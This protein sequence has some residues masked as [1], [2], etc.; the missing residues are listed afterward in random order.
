M[1]NVARQQ[2]QETTPTMLSV[3]EWA[4]NCFH[5]IADY[6]NDNDDYYDDNYDDYHDA[7]DNKMS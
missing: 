7:D 4:G 6:H 1:R 5:K 3:G 2:L